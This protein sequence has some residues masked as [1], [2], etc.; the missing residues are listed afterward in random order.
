MAVRTVAVVVA[1]VCSW[2]CGAA[3]PAQAAE[4]PGSLDAT[5]GR[6]PASRIQGLDAAPDG[7]I[8]AAGITDGYPLLHPWVRAYL[9]S[10]EPDPGFGQ[11]GTVQ[12][13]DDRR[14]V[15]GALVQPDG[16]VLVAQTS[17]PYSTP[18]SAHL[19]RRLT[20]AGLPDP[21]F[22]TGGSI[23]PQLGAGTTLTDIALQPNGRLV[24][25]GSRAESSVA[26]IVIVVARYLPDGSPD[27]SFGSNGI[28]EVLS[29]APE[30]RA[31]V[32]PQPDGGLV[33]TARRAGVPVIARLAADGQ[34]DGSFGAGGLAP[35][36]YGRTGWADQVYPAYG[37]A[38]PVVLSDGRI[39]LALA[40]TGPRGRGYRM[41]LIGLTKD[42][43]PDRGFGKLGRALA[44]RRGPR[45]AGESVQVAVGDRRGAILVAGGYWNG[46]EFA[47]DLYTLIRRFRA[48]GG[49][50]LSFGRRGVVRGQ[51]RGGSG[52]PVFEQRLA[53]VDEDTLVDAEH[54]YD[55]KYGFWG[56][57]ALR[58][59]N[60]GYDDDP[61]MISIGARGCR[62]V[63]V[64][65]ADLSGLERVVVR[66]DGPL[67]RRT[68]AKR[69]R[70]RLPE[71]TERVSV[72]ATDLAGNTSRRS[73]RL[74]SC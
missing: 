37:P 71:G 43:H 23:H 31:A 20:R 73:A 7:R 40:F 34:L 12:L 18:P 61:P 22:G 35:V 64:R 48:D 62:A 29:G 68:R 42:G 11:Q 72:R 33:L 32:T 46:D 52:Y 2:L 49:P 15:V 63:S 30:S 67:L 59:I 57:A 39:R 25:A 13:E 60:A 6:F 41:A 53:M 47:F 55:G 5:L 26:P 74:P 1:A 8:V 69:F 19:V 36:Q 65:I 16:R 66:G 4:R 17:D 51:L 21:S 50:D 54:T 14:F 3:I 44:P 28:T 70:V 10:G 27:T 9:P 56:D 58:T 45:G 24:V 38:P